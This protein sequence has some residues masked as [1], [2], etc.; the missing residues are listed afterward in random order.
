[1]SY[2]EAVGYKPEVYMSYTL[3][4]FSIICVE[5]STYLS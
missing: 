5:I 3:S 4:S 2:N 1:M